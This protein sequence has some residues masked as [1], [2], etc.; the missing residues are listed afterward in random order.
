MGLLTRPAASV[1]LHEDGYLFGR[2]EVMKSR[3]ALLCVLALLLVSGLSGCGGVQQAVPLDPGAPLPHALA[4][5][6]EVCR[7]LHRVS[8]QSSDECDDGCRNLRRIQSH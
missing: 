3:F 6:D 8:S 4:G 7:A 1:P 5:C 2:G